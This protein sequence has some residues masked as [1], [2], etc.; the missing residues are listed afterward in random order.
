MGSAW[1]D[2]KA[3]PGFETHD[4]VVELDLQRSF[5]NATG[6]P[7]V[8]PLG[9]GRIGEHLDQPKLSKT[10]RAMFGPN[11]LRGRFPALAVVKLYSVWGHGKTKE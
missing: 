2:H 6:V 8:A 7:D 4:L 10:I 9:M 3:V 11:A 1:R 5:Q